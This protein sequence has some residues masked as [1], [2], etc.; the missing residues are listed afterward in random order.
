MIDENA[1]KVQIKFEGQTAVGYQVMPNFNNGRVLIINNKVQLLPGR[2]YELPINVNENL[3]NH[4]LFKL[5]GKYKS[6]LY[7]TD[8]QNNIAR[9]YTH[10]NISIENGELLGYLI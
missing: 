5:T 6:L 4:Y 3:D 8:I 2:L 9:C 7:V 10:F 1:I